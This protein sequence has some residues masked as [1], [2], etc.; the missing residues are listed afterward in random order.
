MAEGTDIRQWLSDLAADEQRTDS[1]R[2]AARLLLKSPR[3]STPECLPVEVGAWLQDCARQVFVPSASST[4]QDEIRVQDEVYAA[5]QLARIAN[6]Q[7]D[8]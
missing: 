3:Q 2:A 8:G 7:A 4:L 1:E 6:V 5:G